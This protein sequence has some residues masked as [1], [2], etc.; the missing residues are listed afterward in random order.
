MIGYDAMNIGHTWLVENPVTDD[1]LLNKMEGFSEL[2]FSDM[3][4][5]HPRCQE[6]VDGYLSARQNRPGYKSRTHVSATINELDGYRTSEFLS[7]I[8]TPFYVRI[9]I[10]NCRSA[11]AVHKAEA[12]RALINM[13]RS[14]LARRAHSSHASSLVV[15]NIP[16]LFPEGSTQWIKLGLL[17]TVISLVVRSNIFIFI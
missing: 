7:Y 1:H 12:A 4:K 11:N 13:T 5:V 10:D 2:V 8:L 15:Q 9:L 6:I 17:Q 14:Q 16:K 3:I